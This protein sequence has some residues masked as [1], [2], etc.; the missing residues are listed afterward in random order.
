MSL[1]RYFERNRYA[2]YY[3]GG[4]LWYFYGRDNVPPLGGPGYWL[5]GIEVWWVR[6]DV[7]P[8][9][10]INERWW[11]VPDYPVFDIRSATYQ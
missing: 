5:F 9:Y 4:T 11:F 2:D 6:W 7:V 1:F 3:D 10:D 8:D